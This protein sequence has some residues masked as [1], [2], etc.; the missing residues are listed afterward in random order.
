M[1]LFGF[2][3]LPW[4]FSPVC[5]LFALYMVILGSMCIYTYIFLVQVPTPGLVYNTYTSIRLVLQ[6]TMSVTSWE[7]FPPVCGLHFNG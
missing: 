6:I 2:I 1:V 3:L 7:V 4:K 5:C